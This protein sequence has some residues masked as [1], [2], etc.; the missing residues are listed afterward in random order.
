MVGLLDEGQPGL[1][2]ERGLTALGQQH[3]IWLQ[4]NCMLVPEKR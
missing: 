3:K 4:R 2:P 1:C